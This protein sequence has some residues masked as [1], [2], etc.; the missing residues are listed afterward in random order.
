[1]KVSKLISVDPF[2]NRFNRPGKPVT[3]RTYEIVK[4]GLKINDFAITLGEYVKEIG[5]GMRGKGTEIVG[6]KE[7]YETMLEFVEECDRRFDDNKLGVFLPDAGLVEFKH[8]GH[9][10]FGM[11]DFEERL[12]EDIVGF[13]YTR[14]KT[15]L[16]PI[17]KKS[18]YA[19]I[20]R[21]HINPGL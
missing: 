10:F 12:D 19:E 11:P 2:V 15:H 5:L 14:E 1:M 7:H 3:C 18:H 4:I 13:Y 9:H 6:G 8:D 21:K 16:Y 20:I 17:I